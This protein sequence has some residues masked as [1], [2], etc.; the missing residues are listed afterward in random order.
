MKNLAPGKDN[1]PVLIGLPLAYLLDLKGYDPPAAAKRLTV[2]MLFMQ[3]E[4]DFQ[5][6]M[7]DF[8]LWK[9]ALG[10]RPGATFVSYPALNHL[11]LAGE[12]KSSP[13]EYR[14]PGHFSAEAAGAIATWLL[15]PDWR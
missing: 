6:T 12:G 8:G 5:V 13:A 1:P 3:G 7:T 2:P 10:G 4:R 11:F 15:T 14:V 9:A